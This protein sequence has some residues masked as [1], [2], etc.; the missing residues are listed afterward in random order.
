MRPRSRCGYGWSRVKLDTV[1]TQPPQ[2]RHAF[3]LPGQMHAI[4]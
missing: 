4:A 2:R 1:Q 3:G